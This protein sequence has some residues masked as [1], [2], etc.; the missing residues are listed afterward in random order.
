VVAEPFGRLAYGT[1]SH[2]STAIS[3]LCNNAYP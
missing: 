1:S 3:E 2:H